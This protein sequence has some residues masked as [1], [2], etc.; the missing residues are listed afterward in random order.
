MLLVKR[1]QGIS[2][3]E[4]EPPGG[5]LKDEDTDIAAQRLMEELT[6]L[7]NI[8]L[9]QLKAFGDPHRFPLGRVI[10]IG[11]YSLI[12][13]E[14]YNVNAGLTASEANWDKIVEVLQ[15]IYDHNKILDYSLTHLR[16]K[17]G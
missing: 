9:E 16:R 3:G 11:Y 4:W 14:D 17:L 2:K 6:V 12:K 1:A 5:I 7:D 15:L 13:R 10:T 8:Y